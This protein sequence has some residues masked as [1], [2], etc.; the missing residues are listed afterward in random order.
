MAAKKFEFSE[1]SLRDAER[2]GGKNAALGE[3][4]GALKRKRVHVPDGFA[5]TAD[6]FRLFLRENKINKK[7]EAVKNVVREV[8]RAAH[9]ADCKVRICSEAPSDYPEFA[10]FLARSGIDSISINPDRF[11]ET[12]KIVA[13]GVRKG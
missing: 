9:K 11:I 12:K 3:M 2:V 4:I 5:T 6:A 8:V 1:V 7:N 10:A 13:K